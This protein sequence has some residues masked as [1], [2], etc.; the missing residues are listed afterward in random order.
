[1]RVERNTETQ[2]IAVREA[3][4]TARTKGLAEPKTCHG[5]NY[6][7]NRTHDDTIVALCRGFSVDGVPYPPN[8]TSCPLIR[9]CRKK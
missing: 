7:L 8:L 6:V 9:Y 3:L 4:Q 5:C 1:M 2:R